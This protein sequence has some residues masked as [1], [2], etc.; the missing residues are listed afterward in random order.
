[1][2][3]FAGKKYRIDP[4]LRERGAPLTPEALKEAAVGNVEHILEKVPVNFTFF[5]SNRSLA[6][7]FFLPSP[8]FFSFF[9]PRRPSFYPIHVYIHRP[10]ITVLASTPCRLVPLSSLSA[11]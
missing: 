1:M 9:P 3:I 8:F 11:P 6:K 5:S 2:I 4:F 10:L 7:R